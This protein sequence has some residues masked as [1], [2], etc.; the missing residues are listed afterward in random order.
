MAGCN[1]HLAVFFRK[2][3]L[4]E[5]SPGKAITE[6]YTGGNDTFRQECS[7]LVL[8]GRQKRDRPDRPFHPRAAFKTL[9]FVDTLF[10]V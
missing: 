6:S 8:P 3:P 4:Q 7:C 10:E 9:F 1:Q 2:Q 5:F